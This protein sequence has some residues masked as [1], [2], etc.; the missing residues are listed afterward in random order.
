MRRLFTGPFIPGRG[1]STPRVNRSKL[2]SPIL[3]IPSI[4]SANS[5]TKGFFKKIPVRLVRNLKNI[6]IVCLDSAVLSSVSSFCGLYELLAFC[7]NRSRS[8]NRPHSISF[9][10][11]LTV[12]NRTNNFCNATG[13]V[14]LLFSGF[15]NCRSTYGYEPRTN[16]KSGFTL[17]AIPSRIVKL[18]M[19]IVK[20]GGVENLRTFSR[21]ISSNS[22][23]N[24]AKFTSDAFPVPPVDFSSAVRKRGTS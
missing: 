24:F 5:C 22:D 23:C 9:S 2:A 12:N 20:K 11:P 8:L 14:S 21:L 6:S 10:S 1:G 18:R 3:A 19:M 7:A 4:T 13:V 17:N 15:N 16:R